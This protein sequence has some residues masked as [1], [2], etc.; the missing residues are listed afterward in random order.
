MATNQRLNVTTTQQ[1][2]SKSEATHQ[3]TM[4]TTK[5]AVAAA[6]N[7]EQSGI[8]LKQLKPSENGGGTADASKYSPRS[9]RGEDNN[10]KQVVSSSSPSP[11]H[12]TPIKKAATI[13]SDNTGDDAYEYHQQQRQTALQDVSPA[14]KLQAESAESAGASGQCKYYWHPRR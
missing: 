10:I 5:A 9:K 1:T 3:L 13:C 6:E 11:R 8:E 7:S 12:R 4:D 2:E 14:R